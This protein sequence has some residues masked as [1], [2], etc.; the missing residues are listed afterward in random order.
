M[1]VFLRTMQLYFVAAFAFVKSISPKF[2]K[3]VGQKQCLEGFFQTQHKRL[4]T[5]GEEIAFIEGDGREKE[6]L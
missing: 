4:L 1:Y 6:I 3:M 2:G 5:H